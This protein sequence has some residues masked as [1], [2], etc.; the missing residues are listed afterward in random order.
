MR[1]QKA[2]VVVQQVQDATSPSNI[3]ILALPLI[4]NLLP[5]ALFAELSFPGL[6]PYCLLNDVLTTLPMAIKGVELVQISNR[7]FTIVLTRMTDTSPERESVAAE[8]WVAE[9]HRVESIQPIGVAF[10]AVAGAML[11]LGVMVDACARLFMCC[12]QPFTMISKKLCEED[13][14]TLLDDE[15]EPELIQLEAEEYESTV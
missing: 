5:I 15:S 6:M 10:I 9:F 14:A 1:V 12:G 4:L 13:E 3:A 7:R 2:D 8:M 11:V